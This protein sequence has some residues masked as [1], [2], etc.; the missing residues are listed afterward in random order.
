MIMIVLIDGLVVVR[1]ILVIK[2]YLSEGS[3]FGKK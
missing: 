2:L 3:L 1:M